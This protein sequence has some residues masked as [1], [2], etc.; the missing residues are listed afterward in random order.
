[1]NLLFLLI[2]VGVKI[3]F[4]FWNDYRVEISLYRV[5][6]LFFRNQI[7]NE[8]ESVGGIEREYEQNVYFC[9][10]WLCNVDCF[11]ESYRLIYVF[12]GNFNLC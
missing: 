6:I 7:V 12:F 11:D 8:C 2:Y 1:M 3:Y 5:K 10:N 9:C 4:F